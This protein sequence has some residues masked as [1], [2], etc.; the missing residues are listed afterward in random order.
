M[1]ATNKPKLLGR[2]HQFDWRRAALIGLPVIA[3]GAIV[4]WTI[5]AAGTPIAFET[6][7]GTLAGGGAIKANAA[8]SG[9]SAVQ[10]A[11]TGS[12]C[13]PQNANVTPDYT[14]PQVTNG[15][16]PILTHIPTTKPVIF[17]T[18]D[19]GNGPTED[20]PT[21][22]PC[23]LK[24]TLFIGTHYTAGKSP[25]WFAGLLSEG[26]I[27]ESFTADHANF[28]PTGAPAMSYDA[29][30]ADIAAGITTLNTYLGG[31]PNYRP[32][33]KLFRAPFGVANTD[34]QKAVYDL[35]LAAIIKW[36]IVVNQD[37]SITYSYGNT[38]LHP[39]DIVIMHFY[40]TGNIGT[41]QFNANI[42]A[43]IAIAKAANLT[44]VLLEDWLK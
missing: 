41:S 42:A 30:K 38:A 20:T 8:A 28:A 31:N 7:S 22:I 16:A 18:I 2:P 35:G 13:P 19:N 3:L 27:A 6:E 14:L 37:S 32:N 15:E 33:P 29:Q 17:L 44:P 4:I 26:S 21:S 24:A 1:T 11:A 5:F 39:G 36:N 23:N 34:T 43:F 40:S 12:N 9:G 25:N 10:F